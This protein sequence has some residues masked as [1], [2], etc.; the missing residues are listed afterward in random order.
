MKSYILAFLLISLYLVSCNTKTA[1]TSAPPVNEIAQ[2]YTGPIIDV[3][4]HAF[5]DDSPMLGKMHPPT[6]RGE[7]FQG[8]STTAE[9]KEKTLEKFRQHNVVKAVVTHGHLW[10]DEPTENIMI[11]GYGKSIDDLRNQY[12][13]GKL[14]V[15]G[16]LAPF[17]SEMLADD[18]AMAPYFGLAQELDIPVGFHI[19]PGG[20]NYGFHVLPKML[21]GMRTYNANPLQLEEVL[22]KYPDLKIYVMHGGWPYIEDMKALMYAHP[23][24]Y[25][26]VA[27]INWILPVEEFHYYLKSMVTAGFGDRIMYGSDQMSWPDVID[28][29]IESVNS[30]D[31]LTLEQKEDIF[32]D[33]A[34]NFLEFT[35]EEIRKHKKQ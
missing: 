27:V 8:V 12:K 6:L 26:D 16:E 14:Q 9:Q 31:F 15:L 28:V 34:A 2:K 17:Y 19:L 33:N 13:E 22:V 1:V 24:I 3:H 35:E 29:A 20:P 10:V 30:A 21:G 5:S 32:Y 18:S 23:N 11:G 25:V 7:T 4:V